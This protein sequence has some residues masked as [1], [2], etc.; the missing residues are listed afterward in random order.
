MIK[1][2]R[3]QSKQSRQAMAQQF[4]TKS[5][6][7][8]TL[9]PLC[10]TMAGVCRRT[11]ETRNAV[12]PCQRQPLFVRLNLVV[13]NGLL[14]ARSS[15]DGGRV[16]KESYGVHPARRIPAR[17]RWKECIDDNLCSSAI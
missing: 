1:R 3:F 4:W 8:R 2:R 11:T 17:C 15:C 16:I 7:Q 12:L 10:F 14:L 5:G 6:V 13:V 9:S